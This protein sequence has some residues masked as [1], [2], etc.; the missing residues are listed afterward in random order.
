MN[1]QAILP[2]EEAIEAIIDAAFWASLRREEGYVPKISLALLAPE[3]AVHPMMLRAVAAA[4]PG[5]ARARRA[6]RR[7]SGHPS[8]RLARARASCASGARRASSRPS[9]SC[10][11]S[12]RRGCSSS[13][14]TGTEGEQVRQRRGA[15]RRS[16]QDDRRAGVEPARLS[17][18]CSRRSSGSIRRTRRRVNVLVQ[19]AVSMRAHGRGGS[20]L[21]V[22]AGKRRLARID[23]RS[24]SPTRSSPAVR[25]ARRLWRATLRTRRRRSA[26]GSGRTR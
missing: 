10:S 25:R 13:S 18:R 20:L 1:G 15:R 26:A 22:P 14:T 16:D 9:A 11:K 17:R 6:R 3:Q 2:D 12:P 5:G 23:R 8:R 4:Q 19:L 7:A 21:V 24:R